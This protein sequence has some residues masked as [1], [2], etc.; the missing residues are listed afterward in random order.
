MKKYKIIAL[1]G[2]AGAGK[3]ALMKRILSKC[4]YK[5]HEIVSCT[6]RPPREGEV[7]GVNYF[8]LT[9]EQ[10]GD[11]MLNHEILEASI[12][13]DWFY[14]TEYESLRSDCIN[15]GVFNPD[16]IYALLD[17]PDIDLKVYY[18]RASAKA[19]L[20][21]QLNRED[22]PNVDEIVRRYTADE[23]DFYDLDFEYTEINNESLSD[24]ESATQQILGENS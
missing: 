17:R 11:K 6:T 5:W 15:I 1:I 12:F 4:D 18:V 3:D 21:R 7:N 2:K 16:G 10:F 8:F 23:K 13:N 24:F 14:G 9:K 22:N 19:R 20:L